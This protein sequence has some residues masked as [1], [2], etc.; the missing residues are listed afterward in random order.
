[1]KLD[2]VLGNEFNDFES[3]IGMNKKRLL[4]LSSSKNLIPP[5]QAQSGCLLCFSTTN[6]S[7]NEDSVAYNIIT[8]EI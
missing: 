6:V 7:L 1:M 4:Q 2:K 8:N 5:C 3:R